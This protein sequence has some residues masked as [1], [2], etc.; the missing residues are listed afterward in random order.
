MLPLSNY[1][2]LSLSIPVS[3]KFP[4][5]T[6]ASVVVP[7]PGNT[8]PSSSQQL[9][10]HEAPTHTHTPPRL[11]SQLPHTSSHTKN[12]GGG[13]IAIAP[14]PI[15]SGPFPPPALSPKRH[16]FAFSFPFL[17]ASRESLCFCP[18][19]C[20]CSSARWKFQGVSSSLF[21]SRVINVAK[22]PARM[23]SPRRFLSPR[24]S[25]RLCLNKQ[26]I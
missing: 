26:A 18:A 17:G 11:A 1:E 10:S 5:S 25:Q 22:P 2:A 15:P 3:K 19:P 6:T 12:K 14:I 16:L 23:L 20:F 21:H 4:L 24:T 8:A 13:H 9:P 7:H